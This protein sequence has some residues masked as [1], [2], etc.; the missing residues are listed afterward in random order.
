M[1]FNGSTVAVHLSDEYVHIL[2]SLYIVQSV[3]A[4]YMKHDKINHA[5]QMAGDTMRLA[6]IMLKEHRTRFPKTEEQ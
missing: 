6:D 4:E 1:T 2:F 5:A 3:V